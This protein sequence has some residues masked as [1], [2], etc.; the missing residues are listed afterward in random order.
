MT[1]IVDRLRYRMR[2][3][4]PQL[5]VIGYS[6]PGVTLEQ[7]VTE[8]AAEIERLRALADDLYAA[9]DGLGE[10]GELEEKMP[11]IAKVKA[12]WREARQR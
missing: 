7:D 5:C 12:R 10:P 1:D 4:E 3:A 6:D 9:L 2:T 11:S 8:A